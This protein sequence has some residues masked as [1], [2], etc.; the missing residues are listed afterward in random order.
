MVVNVCKGEHKV[1]KLDVKCLR[2][3]QK[4]IQRHQGPTES[5]SIGNGRQQMVTSAP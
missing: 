5:G 2:F 1:I 4:A 3:A